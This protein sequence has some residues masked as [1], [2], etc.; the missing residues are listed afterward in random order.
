MHHTNHDMIGE[1]CVWIFA[2]DL[3]LTDKDKMKACVEHCAR[4]PNVE[5]EWASDEP[6]EVFQ[7]VATTPTIDKFSFDWVSQ[8]LLLFFHT[9]MHFQHA[10]VQYYSPNT[11]DTMQR[12]LHANLTLQLWFNYNLSWKYMF[13]Q[14]FFWNV[15]LSCC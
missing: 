11:I 5:F 13:L 6:P 14:F 3:A 10:E 2:G 12:R 4:L 8:Y 9:I 7:T 15:F 1:N